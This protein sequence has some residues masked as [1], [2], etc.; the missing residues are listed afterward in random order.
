MGAEILAND[1][2]LDL[3]R[4]DL[5]SVVR[6]RIGETE[7]NLDRLFHASERECHPSV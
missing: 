4:I 1:L 6:E 5:A 2:G 3:Y 7:K